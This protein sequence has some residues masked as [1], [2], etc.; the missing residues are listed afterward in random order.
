MIQMMTDTDRSDATPVGTPP[1]PGEDPGATDDTGKGT[2]AATGRSLPESMVAT[3]L[4]VLVVI[5][6][7]AGL[8]VTVTR[9]H[10]AD[11]VS[12]ARAS[13]LAAA[14]RYATDLT[15]YDYRHLDT[16]FAAVL[17]HGSPSFKKSFTASSNA[18]RS[19]LIKYDAT[20]KASVLAAGVT[21]ASTSRAVVLVFL[22][23]TVTNTVQK[24]GPT[25]D[26]SRLAMTLV[27]QGGQWVIDQVKLFT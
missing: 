25:S 12:S 11:A 24:G 10:H 26:Q 21:S 8:V 4:A 5:G 17:D 18:L 27:R 16:D 15:T 1:G 20:S 3:V 7:A 2:A 23:Q 9:L 13:A 6:L 14:E 19:F 22:N